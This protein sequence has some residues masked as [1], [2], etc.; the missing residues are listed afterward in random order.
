MSL[1]QLH[2]FYRRIGDD[3]D[4]QRALDGVS[5]EEL[6]ERLSALGAEHG[7]DFSADEVRAMMKEG[8]GEEDGV[9]LSE[10]ELEGVSGGVSTFSYDYMEPT[11]GFQQLGSNLDALSMDEKAFPGGTW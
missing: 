7:H 6:P 8:E 11:S 10:E 4:L 2:A 9:E 5:D 1:E 3:S